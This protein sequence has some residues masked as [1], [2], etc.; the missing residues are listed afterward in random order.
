MSRGS[1]RAVAASGVLIAGLA[2]GSPTTHAAPGALDFGPATT[3]TTAGTSPVDLATADFDGDGVLDIVVADY[4]ERTV[5]VLVGHGDGTFSA[6]APQ[7]TGGSG[8]ESIVAADL[9]G[10]GATDVAVADIGGTVTVLLGDGTGRLGAPAALPA[11][12]ITSMEV[13]AAD[14]DGDGDVDL[15]VANSG[16]RNVGVLLNAGSGT[17]ADAV[18]YRVGYVASRPVGLAAG[19]LDGDGAVDLAAISTSGPSGI[20][21]VLRNAGNGTYSVI[22]NV[23]SGGAHPDAVQI[24]DIDGDGSADVGV[25]NIALAGTL[26]VLAGDGGG[27]F[28]SLTIVATGGATPRGFAIGDLDG[29]GWQ[30][31]A[32]ANGGSATVG[33]LQGDGS[34]G[35]QPPVSHP[36]AGDTPL[37]VGLADVDADGH[38][39]VVVPNASSGTVAVL[40]NRTPDVTPTTTVVVPP[41]APSLW[42]APVTFRVEVRS[43]G[44]GVPTGTAQFFVDGIASGTPVEL[45]D[46][47]ATSASISPAV[48]GHTVTAVY[49]G[50]AEHLPSASAPAAHAVVYGLS[51]LAPGIDSVMRPGTTLIAKVVVTDALGAPIPDSLAK[52][53]TTSEPCGV[54]VSAAGAQTLAPSCMRYNAVSDRFT[55]SWHLGRTQGA[56]SLMTTIRYPDTDAVTTRTVDVVVAR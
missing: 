52:A 47:S 51:V 26:A 3:S 9:D 55:R 2:T 24:G 27:H 25:A 54:V 38:L 14:L 23:G 48:G 44:H 1:F 56:V 49:A 17:F 21:S 46:G 30:D 42:R 15:A 37:T 53:L 4:A 16:S 13:V 43:D 5:A 29:D 19:D 28:S 36:T 50:D 41:A 12:G 39:D 32:V 34:G 40:L 33:I 10:D 18:A 22:A 31:L 35:L 11:G 6:T 7:P 45:V 20:V 8:P